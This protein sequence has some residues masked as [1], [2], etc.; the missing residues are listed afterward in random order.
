MKKLNI[1]ATALLG[2]VA[3]TSCETDRDNNPTLSVPKSFELLA[4]EIGSNVVNLKNSESVRFHAKAAPNYGFPTETSY[5]IELSE[6]QDFS[7]ATKIAATDT[8]GKSITYDA[9]ANEIDF[10]ILQLRNIP[11]DLPTI[12]WDEVIT[13]YARMVACPTNLNEPAYYVYSNIQSFKVT[14]YFLKEALPEIWFMVG[15]NIGDGSWGDGDYNNVGTGLVPMYIKAGEEYNRFTGKG[16]IEYV[17]YFEEGGMKILAPRGIKNHPTAK[18][19]NGW[20]YGMCGDGKNFSDGSG[21][22]S[23]NGGDDKGNITVDKKGWYRLLL[24]NNAK[25]GDET[26]KIEA[27]EYDTA[28]VIYTSM[29][30]GDVAL[31]AMNSKVENHD[32]Y[33]TITLAAPAEL[34]FVSNDNTEWGTDAFPYGISTVDGS[35]IPVAKGSYQIFFNDVTGAFLFTEIEE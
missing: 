7:D 25:E 14:A 35:K 29:K 5:W 13:L 27:Y 31:T 34:T 12:D 15:A 17:G 24:D 9:P 30:F 3:L 16:V 26:L 19:I 28:P 33:G 20:M 4:P 21:Y 23:R 32:W 22:V 10:A 6:N 11:E 1:L 18:D 8:K 2:L